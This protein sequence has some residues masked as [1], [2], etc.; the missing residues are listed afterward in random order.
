[1]RITYDIT[2]EQ[3]KGNKRWT[4]LLRSPSGRYLGQYTCA[5]ECPYLEGLYRLRIYLHG[6]VWPACVLT[7]G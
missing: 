5:S 2:K 4:F 3:R 7:L 1:M 6:Q